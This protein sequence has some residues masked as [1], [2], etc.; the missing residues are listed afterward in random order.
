MFCTRSN[1]MCLG[2]N[3]LQL[4][5]NKMCLGNNLLQ[6]KDNKMCLGNN[7]LQLKDNKM[8]LGNNLLQLKDGTAGNPIC[9]QAIRQGYEMEPSALSALGL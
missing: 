8:C 4:K 9:K 6:L 5:D 3:L 2:N 7:L 1:K